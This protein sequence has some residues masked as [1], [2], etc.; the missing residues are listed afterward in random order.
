MSLLT[1]LELRGLVRNVGGRFE[2]TLRGRAAS[3]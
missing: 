2:P 1:R 3:G